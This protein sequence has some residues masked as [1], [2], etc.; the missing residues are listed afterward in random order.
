MV[1]R[2]V[3]QNNGK[4]LEKIEKCMSMSIVYVRFNPFFKTKL[5]PWAS[6]FKKFTCKIKNLEHSLKP[7]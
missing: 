3:A 6:Y 7:N 2:R 5:T 1:D 4:M